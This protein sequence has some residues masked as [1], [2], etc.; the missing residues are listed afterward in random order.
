MLEDK[1]VSCT[2]QTHCATNLCLSG[3]ESFKL[4]KSKTNVIRGMFS[5][6]KFEF[7]LWELLY[8]CMLKTN[9]K[10]LIVCGLPVHVMLHLAWFLVISH[11]LFYVTSVRFFIPKSSG[12]HPH[13]PPSL[14]VCG[15]F[16]AQFK[17][18]NSNPQFPKPLVDDVCCSMDK[19]TLHEHFQTQEIKISND[20]QLNLQQKKS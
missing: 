1:Q 20:E 13:P 8:L 3:S 12:R 11:F 6:P 4:Q 2:L 19:S 5:I 18:K 14:T 17:P 16:N 15:P 10:N 9:F 7:I